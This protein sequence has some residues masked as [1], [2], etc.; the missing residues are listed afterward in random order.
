MK[1]GGEEEEEE[2]EQLPSGRRT[3]G[4]G[5][6]ALPAPP[7]SGPAGAAGRAGVAS[8]PP[9]GGASGLGRARLRGGDCGGRV[10]SAQDRRRPQPA[11]EEGEPT[12][13]LGPA[14]WRL[15]FPESPTWREREREVPPVQC[16]GARASSGYISEVWG[17]PRSFASLALALLFGAASCF[18]C[19]LLLIR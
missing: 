8:A 6:V 13:R 3:R 10:N 14:A 11:P 15:H 12:G 16:A 18:I 1:L 4:P 17:P 2:E 19:L 7:P 5:P 9:G